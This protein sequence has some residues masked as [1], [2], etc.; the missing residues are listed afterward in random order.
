[1][2]Y[3]Y[4]DAFYAVQPDG[5]LAWRF[6]LDAPAAFAPAIGADGT[7]FFSKGEAELK[8]ENELVALNTD[9]TLNGS[10]PPP[11]NASQ[12]PP[13]WTPLARS[14]SARSTRCMRSIPTAR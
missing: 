6:A 2:Y 14:M 8:P 1:M 11:H 13:R 3:G 4:G 7:I 5:A 9:G 12:R 10:T